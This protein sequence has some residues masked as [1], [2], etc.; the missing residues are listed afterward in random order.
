[1]VEDAPAEVEMTFS[2]EETFE[3]EKPEKEASI[4]A[5][6][7]KII[8]D[9][10]ADGGEAETLDPAAM[11]TLESIAGPAFRVPDEPVLSPPLPALPQK[12]E[13]VRTM[14]RLASDVVRCRA[15]EMSGRIVLEL[16]VSGETGK[17]LS[18]KTVD[19]TFKGTSTGRCAAKVVSDAQF[20]MFERP[21]LTIRYP[22]DI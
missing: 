22:Y 11:A 12:D 13:I 3:S 20:S 14:D 2:E 8:A 6:E 5:E 18:A 7:E 10:P 17:V 9:A 15:G 16:V 19:D 4:P 1:V 21:R